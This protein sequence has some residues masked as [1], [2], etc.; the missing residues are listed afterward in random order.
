MARAGSGTRRGQRRA[1]DRGPLASARR[2]SSRRCRSGPALSRIRQGPDGRREFLVDVAPG[3]V[4]RRESAP[5][6]V[7]RAPRA[8]Q[9]LG[10]VADQKALVLEQGPP[11]ADHRVHHV[12]RALIDES[13]DRIGEGPNVQIVPVE[14]DDVGLGSRGETAEIVSSEGAGASEVG[15]VE[16]GHGRRRLVVLLEELAGQR[17]RPHLGQHVEGVD[18]GAHDHVDAGGAIAVEA[19]QADATAGE[20]GGGVHDGGPGGGEDLEVAAVRIGGSAVAGQV[21]GGGQQHG[22][23]QH[24]LVPEEGGRGLAGGAHGV[25]ELEHLLAEVHG[26]SHAEPRGERARVAQ[27]PR[28]GVVELV[29]GDDAAHAAIRSAV[30]LLD[31]GGGG[32]KSTKTGRFIH[33][34]VETAGVVEEVAAAQNHRRVIDPHTEGARLFHHGRARVRSGGRER[35]HGGNAVADEGGEPEAQRGTAVRIPHEG[36]AAVAPRGQI[37]RE[38]GAEEVATASIYEEAAALL[39]GDVGVSTDLPRDHQ[40]PARVESV[41]PRARVRAPDVDDAIA[42]V[43]ERPVAQEAMLGA[44]EGD[45]QAPLDAGARHGW[46]TPARKRSPRRRSSS[47][48]AMRTRETEISTTAAAAT[49]GVMVSLTPLQSWRGSVRRSGLPTKRMTRSSSNEV[50]KAKTAPETTPGRMMGNVTF[51]NAWSGEAP[52]PAAARGR[53]TSK[54]CRVAAMVMTTKGSASTVCAST[55]PQ[56]LPTRPSRA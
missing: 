28:G 52:R 3:P 34:A 35:D 47:T 42:F 6:A 51:R 25:E 48:T 2:S 46:G 8:R 19:L 55:S 37:V 15:G 13:P 23:A 5:H 7:G 38:A 40:L 44:V 22:G 32:F 10:L 4:I 11:V 36:E 41:V 45:D 33:D 54:P 39:G 43:D 31:E 26:E 49:A 56:K 50:T 17:G 9:D 20:A 27:E 12:R 21:H 16:D 18:V 29:D 1:R 53:F 24:A 14:E 30:V